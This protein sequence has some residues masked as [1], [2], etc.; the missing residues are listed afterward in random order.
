MARCGRPR[1]GQLHAVHEGAGRRRGQRRGAGQ[2]ARRR[3]PSARGA[4]AG[5]RPRG[6]GGRRCSDA[7]G[8]LGEYA[9]PRRGRLGRR[10]A[11][12]AGRPGRGRAAGA[13]GAA[14]E[15]RAVRAAG[16]RAGRAARRASGGPSASARVP[17]RQLHRR[18]VGLAAPSTSRRPPPRRAAVRLPHDFLTE[19]LT[20]AGVTDRGD[21]SGTG[22][23]ALADR[24]VRRGAARRDRASTRRC[25]PRCSGPGEAAGT[26]PRHG[27]PLRAGRAGRRR[28]RRQR[29]RRARPRPRA[30][31]RPVLSLGTS[32]T[33]YAVLAAPADRPDRH[34]GRVRRRRRR[35][36][37]A[38]LHAELHAGRRQG[39]RAARPRP[40][41]RRA[42]R[43]GGLPALPGRRAHARTCRTPPGCCTGLR[44]D[45]TAGQ[46]LQAAYDG[47]VYAL[48]AAL[49][50]VLAVD[51]AAAGGSGA[52]HA[53]AAADRRRRAGRRLAGDRAA[54]VRARGAGA[55]GG[56]TGR[57][58]AR[59]RRRPGCSPARR[60][61]AVAPRWGTARRAAARTPWPRDDEALARLAAALPLAGTCSARWPRGRRG[62]GARQR[63]TWATNG[64]G[65]HRRGARA[66]RR[67]QQG[68]RRR[69]LARWCMGRRSPPAQ[70]AAARA[71]EVRR[72]A[73]GLTRAA[74]VARWSA[75]CW[76]RGL[77]GGA[78]ARRPAA[79]SG[80]PGTAL[81]L[82]E[83]GPGR[84]S[85]P[86][87]ASTTSPPAWWTCAATSGPGAESPAP[88]AAA[89]RPPG[90]RRTGRAGRAA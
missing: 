39:G 85:A 41:G 52:G 40:R 69:N 50:Q 1:R 68:M 83:H 59:R 14:V 76:R 74:V 17:G 46:L 30:R 13:P 18:Q 24:G 55:R 6:S 10:P 22:W 90:P 33:V 31:A 23:W 80:R 16:R 73:V 21:A 75:S 3:T 61:A 37:A 5:E 71:P 45:T 34:G 67:P 65:R 29:G 78:R 32:G 7:L 62:A 63:R 81:A 58:R 36:A 15:R 53:T 44:H 35:L 20:G 12:R 54:A 89:R 47:A 11:A 79:G 27:L 82:S 86:R 48:L 70:R 9:G 8:Q 4:G 77:A 57:A 38:G 19:R 84:A 43:L 25:C 60:A 42:R 2:R 66:A 88:T 28:H 64:R 49:D 72:R 51:R 56:G 26:G 87:S